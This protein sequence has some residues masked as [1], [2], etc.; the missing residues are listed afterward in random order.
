MSTR[1]GNVKRHIND[2]HSGNGKLVTLS[3]YREGVR[4]GAYPPPSCKKRKREQRAAAVISNNNSAGCNCSCNNNNNDAKNADSDRKRSRWIDLSDPLD[5]AEK[6]GKWFDFCEKLRRFRAAG[7]GPA[8]PPATTPTELL[9]G[10][11]C[12]RCLANEVVPLPDPEQGY[13][14]T[15]HKCNEDRVAANASIPNRNEVLA[16]VYTI[17]LPQ[18]LKFA[19][20]RWLGTGNPRYIVAQEVSPEFLKTKAMF[21]KLIDLV[22]WNQNKNKNDNSS[23]NNNSVRR[24][25]EDDDDYP[26][27]LYR[28]IEK[29]RSKMNNDDDDNKWVELQDNEVSDFLHRVH[30]TGAIFAFPNA[31]SK[32]A[33][34]HNV[35]TSLQE[36]EKRYY[37]IKIVS[38]YEIASRQQAEQDAFVNRMMKRMQDKMN[39]EFMAELKEE[40]DD[41]NNNFDDSDEDGEEDKNHFSNLQDEPV[42]AADSNKMRERLRGRQHKPKKREQHLRQQQEKRDNGQSMWIEEDDDEMLRMLNPP[43]GSCFGNGLGKNN[44]NPAQHPNPHSRHY[45]IQ[46]ILGGPTDKESWYL[47]L[48][49]GDGVTR[50]WGFPGDSEH[51]MQLRSQEQ[52]TQGSGKGEVNHQ[53]DG[54]KRQACCYGLEYP[55]RTMLSFLF[56]LPPLEDVELDMKGKGATQDDN[57]N[58]NPFSFPGDKGLQI[59]LAN[60]IYELE[61]IKPDE[62]IFT[63]TEREDY[64]WKYDRTKSFAGRYRLLLLHEQDN[65]S[66]PSTRP[67]TNGK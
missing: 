59:L 38:P 22:I 40:D 12:K 1:G 65:D 57:S 28:A 13:D 67:S 31:R 41:N 37:L 47:G 30:G 58:N 21:P 63:I 2:K 24:V 26:G 15:L 4:T 36:N 5:V 39:A 50:I 55:S 27:Y 32:K 35:D 11:T 9:V 3:V 7:G 33:R 6:M 52:Q 29:S 23:D 48:E 66:S 18:L 25:I 20:D 44:N 42:R 16:K 10:Y 19:L 53:D 61:S 60:G 64:S 49:T 56:G 62:I 45:A 17:R 46:K 43:A 14:I 34:K 54:N 8:V 51:M